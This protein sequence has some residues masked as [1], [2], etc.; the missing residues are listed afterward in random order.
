MRKIIFARNFSGKKIFRRTIAIKKTPTEKNFFIG[1]FFLQPAQI[2]G[3]FSFLS[4][5]FHG[6]IFL[7]SLRASKN[8]I[9]A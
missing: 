2:H 6:E 1:E 5:N 3:N 4:D 7:K 9:A 8:K